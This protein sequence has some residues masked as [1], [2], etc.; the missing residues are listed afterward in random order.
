VGVNLR[1][2]DERRLELARRQAERSTFR[3]RL[4]CVI[5]GPGGKVLGQGHNKERMR[6]M[7]PFHQCTEHAEAAAI[8]ACPNLSKLRGATAYVARV[9]GKGGDRLAMPCARCW[10]E[11]T[12]VGIKAIVWTDESGAYRADVRHY[13]KEHTNA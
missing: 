8:R 6:D 7:A 11:L 4:G 3:Y 13:L 10:G 1:A 5:V 9:D 2:A 12:A